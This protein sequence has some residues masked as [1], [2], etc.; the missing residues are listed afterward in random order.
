MNNFVDHIGAL[1]ESIHVSLLSSYENFKNSQAED[2]LEIL[3][4]NLQLIQLLALV[5]L[6]KKFYVYIIRLFP[7]N[8]DHLLEMTIYAVQACTKIIPPGKSLH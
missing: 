5:V 2:S 3:G 4:R 1:G 6:L 7:V 8:L